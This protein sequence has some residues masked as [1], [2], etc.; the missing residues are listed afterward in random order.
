[1]TSIPAGTA[2]RLGAAGAMP[3]VRRSTAELSSWDMKMFVEA[4]P[5]VVCGNDKRSRLRVHWQ[6][7][8]SKS[9]A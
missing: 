3:S 8:F 7:D 4:V 1:M 9:A 2:K 6:V 5:Q